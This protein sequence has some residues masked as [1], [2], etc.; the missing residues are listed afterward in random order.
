MNFRRDIAATSVLRNVLSQNAAVLPKRHDTQSLAA[1]ITDATT[2]TQRLY[3]LKMRSTRLSV[4][5][6]T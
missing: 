2:S 5:D 1:G 4:K 6:K 3:A